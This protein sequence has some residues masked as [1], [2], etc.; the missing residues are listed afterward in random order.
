MKQYKFTKFIGILSPLLKMW[1]VYTTEIINIFLFTTDR[2]TG[3]QEKNP[4]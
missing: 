4:L 2:N 3:A 1:K